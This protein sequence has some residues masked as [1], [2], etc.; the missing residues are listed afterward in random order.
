MTSQG[1]RLTATAQR[2]TIATLLFLAAAHFAHG[3]LEFH[4]AVYAIVGGYVTEAIFEILKE[5]EKPSIVI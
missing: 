4:V 2:G 1:R 3:V 5:H